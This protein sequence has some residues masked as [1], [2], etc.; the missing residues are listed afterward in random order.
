[1]LELLRRYSD[2]LTG[3]TELPRE[4]AEKLVKQLQSRGE[5]RARDLGRAAQSLVERSL[6]NR[7][8][9]VR[10]MQKEIRSQ[11]SS[12]GLVSRDELE[13]L[14]RRVQEL[15]AAS[16]AKPKAKA[17]ARKPAAARK[18]TTRKTTASRSVPPK[19]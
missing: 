13:R 11:V 3:I 15:E 9:L 1:M 2:A 18:P 6:R 14:K 17:P 4:R 8:E 10:L 7:R 19:A 5:L 12:M 16:K